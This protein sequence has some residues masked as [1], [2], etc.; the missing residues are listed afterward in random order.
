LLQSA[1]TGEYFATGTGES[2]VR[3]VYEGG[4]TG[5]WDPALADRALDLAIGKALFELIE[6]YHRQG[7]RV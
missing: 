7:S 5:S 1:Q 2:S 6:N 3:Q 4:Q